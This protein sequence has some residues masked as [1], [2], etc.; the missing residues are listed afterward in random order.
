MAV[1][2]VP[3][4][5]HIA[6]LGI[7]MNGTKAFADI[8]KDVQMKVVLLDFILWIYDL[9]YVIYMHFIICHDLNL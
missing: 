8:S 6:W 7:F 9:T 5:L 1:I 3:I 4:L 2:I